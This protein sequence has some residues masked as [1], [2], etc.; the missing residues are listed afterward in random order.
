MKNL[1]AVTMVVA[2]SGCATSAISPKEASP[3]PG[4]RLFG[5]QSPPSG[6]H[7][8][9]VVTRDEG[10]MG[11]GCNTLIN[12]DGK[13]VGEIASGEV[14]TF[15]V[16]EGRHIIGAEIDEALCPDVLKEREFTVQGGETRKYRISIDA[17]GSMDLSPTAQ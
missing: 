11:G 12:I 2:L 16:A 13:R 14:A 10:F 5:L 8:N 1:A 9:L 15:Y 4:D 3:I 6:A 7:G 17:T